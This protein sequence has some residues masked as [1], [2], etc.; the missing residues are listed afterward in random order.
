MVIYK[1]NFP[2]QVLGIIFFYLS[3]FISKSSDCFRKILSRNVY[4]ILLDD[5]S[6]KVLL[7]KF[8]KFNT[9][10]NKT[11]TQDDN[12]EGTKLSIIFLC[13]LVVVVVRGHLRPL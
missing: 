5:K 4:H 1:K 10:M 11:N 6:N 9:Q 12:S 7:C 8:D 2:I 3:K 13:N